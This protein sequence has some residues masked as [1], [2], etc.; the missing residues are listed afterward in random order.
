MARMSGKAGTFRMAEMAGQPRPWSAPAGWRNDKRGLP[1][2]II[3][4]GGSLFFIKFYFRLIQ[5]IVG[6]I[7]GSMP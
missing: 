7:V 5:I 3:C 1:L 2:C 4:K 6:V